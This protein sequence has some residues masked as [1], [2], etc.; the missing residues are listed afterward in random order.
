[1]ATPQPV[2][3]DIDPLRCDDCNE[4]CEDTHVSDADVICARCRDA[5]WG[6]CQRCCAWGLRACMATDTL[7]EV[8]D[9]WWMDG[10][11]E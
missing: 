9:G 3:L 5:H 8:C 7:C 1:M 6:Q 4:P 11:E 2:E 10:D